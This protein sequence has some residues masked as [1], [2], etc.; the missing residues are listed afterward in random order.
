[1]AL[2]SLPLLLAGFSLAANAANTPRF[3]FAF[4]SSAYL[5]NASAIAVDPNGY[6]YLAGTVDG[7][8]FT[9]TPGAYQS[10]YPGGTC[11]AGPGAGG[12]GGASPL[13]SRATARS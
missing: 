2:R 10:Q 12:G 5:S 4:P 13:P 1:M 3:T 11:Y 6:T 8:A 7:N 9:A